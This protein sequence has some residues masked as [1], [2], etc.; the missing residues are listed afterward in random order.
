MSDQDEI[1]QGYRD[2]MSRK[3]KPTTTGYTPGPV[4]TLARLSI[5][6]DRY[7]SDMDFR[8]AVDAV[9]GHLVYDSAPDLLEACKFS[10]HT[11]Q[12]LTSHEYSLGGDQLLRVQLDSVIRKAEGRP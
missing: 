5:Q 11:L 3:M 12:H 4:E 1:E 10:L 6:S 7:Q 9:I 2:A 8:D